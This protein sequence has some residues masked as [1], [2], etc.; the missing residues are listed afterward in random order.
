METRLYFPSWKFALAAT[1][2]FLFSR[3]ECNTLQWMNAMRTSPDIHRQLPCKENR[4]PVDSS[5]DLLI[6]L[7]VP[8]S[9]RSEDPNF[10]PV[11][12]LLLALCVRS[13]CKAYPSPASPSKMYLSYDIVRYS[14]DL[15]IAGCIPTAWE[16]C[17][18]LSLQSSKFCHGRVGL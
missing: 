3:L 13:V 8:Q 7:K 12:F 16:S 9:T 10:F 5:L 2:H 11:L 6:S 18:G 4:T 14:K 17:D 1:W 15:G